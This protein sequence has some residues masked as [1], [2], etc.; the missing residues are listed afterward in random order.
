LLLSRGIEQV[1]VEIER[2]HHE[3]MHGGALQLD[4]WVLGWCP[5]ISSYSSP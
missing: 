5:S 2:L 1:A 3:I 4:A